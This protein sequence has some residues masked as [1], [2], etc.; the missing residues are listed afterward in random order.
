[1]RLLSSLTIR[2]DCFSPADDLILSNTYEHLTQGLTDVFVVGRTKLVG[3]VET[4][5]IVMVG[6]Q[7]QGQIWIGV[8]DSLPYMA[9]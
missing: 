8:K 1:M 3:G 6:R 4:N 5:V 2:L 7:L 9:F